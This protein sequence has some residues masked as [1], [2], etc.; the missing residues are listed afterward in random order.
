MLS[1]F[2]FLFVLFLF[3]LLG[4]D[5]A[6]RIRLGTRWC[7]S[8]QVALVIEDI[9]AGGLESVSRVRHHVSLVDCFLAGL[10]RVHG[11]VHV[12]P[13]CCRSVLHVQRRRTPRL[14]AR[15]AVALV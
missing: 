5:V 4:T 9:D 6:Q 8:T 7:Q 3:L 11:H 12:A 13:A 14:T 15:G 2:A 10:S 1:L